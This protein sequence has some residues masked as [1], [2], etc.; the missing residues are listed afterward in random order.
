M[1]IKNIFSKAIL[2]A[3]S[4]L[5]TACSDAD[6]AK[7]ALAA[8]GYSDI[9]TNGYAFWGCGRDDTF[10]TN[11]TAKGP[12][13]ITVSGVVCGGWLKGSTIRID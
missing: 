6:G 2:I 1:N 12:T 8:A 11:F 9:Q 5:I 7:K 13:G 4:V 3:A 10:H